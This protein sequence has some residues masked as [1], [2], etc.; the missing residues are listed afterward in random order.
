MYAI[1][2]SGGH[3]YKVAEGDVIAVEKIVGDVGVQVDLANVLF[4]TGKGEGDPKIGTPLVEGAKIIAEITRQGRDK[5]II[6]L[7]K[8]RRKG[9]KKKQ[10]HRQPYTELKITKIS[11]SS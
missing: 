5:K 3:Q 8:K 9:Y 6:V 1:V 7:K 10:G 11:A 2:Q 4:V